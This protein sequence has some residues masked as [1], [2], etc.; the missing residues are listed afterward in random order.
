MRPSRDEKKWRL[1]QVRRRPASLVRS[2]TFGITTQF[3]FPPVVPAL[4]SSRA[5]SAQRSSYTN[6]WLV[7]STSLRN[8]GCR[9]A[10]LTARTTVWFADP[11]YLS[12]TISGR[13][14]PPQSW[15]GHSC[16]LNDAAHRAQR[17]FCSV[18]L[19]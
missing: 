1:S 16:R 8:Y 4:G 14:R 18:H 10:R 5:Y 19:I 12:L 3:A 11:R 2:E 13:T 17:E 15:R 7:L 9:S 6:V